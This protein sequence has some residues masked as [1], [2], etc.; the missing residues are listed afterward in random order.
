LAKI[1]AAGA[2]P[3]VDPIA[4]GAPVPATDDPDEGEDDPKP[5]QDTEGN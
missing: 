2:Q 1:F 3:M 5:G 4:E